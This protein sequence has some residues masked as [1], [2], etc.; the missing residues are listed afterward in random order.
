MI[1]RISSS[2]LTFR[3]TRYAYIRSKYEPARGSSEVVAENEAAF[4]NPHSLRDLKRAFLHLL[5]EDEEFRREVKAIFY[6]EDSTDE[7]Y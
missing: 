6:A 2:S 5:K 7:D 4:L 3:T 1:T